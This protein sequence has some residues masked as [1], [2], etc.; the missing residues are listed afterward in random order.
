MVQSESEAPPGRRPLRVKGSCVGLAADSRRWRRAELFGRANAATSLGS[1]TASSPSPRSGT[2]DAWSAF[3][4]LRRFALGEVGDAVDSA[5]GRA[6]SGLPS[7]CAAPGAALVLGPCRGRIVVE[8]PRDGT[9]CDLGRLRA[10]EPAGDAG[11][12]VRRRGV[13]EAGVVRGPRGLGFV[14]DRAPDVARRRRVVIVAA[15]VPSARDERGDRQPEGV[16]DGQEVAPWNATRELL[17]AS[18]WRGGGWGQTASP[19]TASRLE[20]RVG[21]VRHGEVHG[22]LV[23][24]GAATESCI[25]IALVRRSGCALSEAKGAV[26]RLGRRTVLARVCFEPGSRTRTG[27]RASRPCRAGP[28]SSSGTRYARALPRPSGCGLA[29]ARRGSGFRG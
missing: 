10:S 12:F 28:R 4:R 9:P 5:W 26:R 7:G 8:G 22:L 25:G 29:A 14:V 19:R 16:D 13:A 18:S 11:V 27:R 21:T 15:R 2:G 6:A 24:V 1:A 20:W 17:V 3:W 23:C